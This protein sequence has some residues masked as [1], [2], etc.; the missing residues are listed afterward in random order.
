MSYFVE[1][2]REKNRFGPAPKAASKLERILAFSPLLIILFSSVF[3]IIKHL[4][5]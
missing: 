2:Q 1:A 4:V 3:E 5:M